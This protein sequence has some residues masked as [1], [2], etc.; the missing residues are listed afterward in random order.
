MIAARSAARLRAA[1]CAITLVSVLF[2]R[3]TAG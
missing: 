2:D 1:L 3:G